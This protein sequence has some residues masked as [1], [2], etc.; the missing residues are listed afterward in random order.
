MSM[1]AGCKLVFDDGELLR[2]M[3]HGLTGDVVYCLCSS[4][5]RKLMALIDGDML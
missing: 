3:I 2:V 5:T 4:C 1:C